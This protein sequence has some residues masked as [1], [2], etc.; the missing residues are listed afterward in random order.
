MLVP[1]SVAVRDANAVALAL[2]RTRA[3]GALLDVSAATLGGLALGRAFGRGGTGAAL[4]AAAGVLLALRWNRQRAAA[5][6]ERARPALGSALQ[7]YLEGGGGSLRPQLETWVAQRLG[8]AWLPA[9]LVRMAVAAG[10]AL[11]SQPL[12]RPHVHGTDA[13][14]PPRPGLSVTARLEPPAYAGWP[15]VEVQLPAV[16]GL[17]HSRLLLDVRTTAAGLRWAE[18]GGPEHQLLPVDGRASLSFPLERSGSL[19]L[20]AEGGGPVVLLQLEALPDGAPRVTLAAP[21]TDRTVTAAPG[22]LTLRASAQDDVQVAHLDFRWT[23]ARGSGEGMQFQNGRLPGHLTLQGQTAEAAARLDPLALGMKA[24][25][26]LVLWA[27]AS[28][29][30][31]LD[32]PGVGRSEARLVHWEEALVDLS[33]SVAGARLPPPLSQPSERELLARTER[34]VRSGARGARLR[35]QSAALGDLQRHIREAFGFFLQQESRSGLELDVD[36]AEVAMNG[37][38]RARRLLAQ[39]VSEMWS[40]EAELATG[41]PA[42]ALA[43]ERAAV[44]ALD[45]AFG[46]ERLALRPF[47]PPDRPI[48]EGRRLSGAQGGLR[49]RADG[50]ATR[51]APDDSSVAQLARRLLLSAEEGVTAETARRL[52]DAL[53]ALPVSTGIAAASL[54]A[55]LYAAEDGV[56]RDAAARAAAVALSRWLRPSPD[57]VPPVSPDEAAV[58]SRLPLRPPRP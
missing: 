50:P 5:A 6:L 38:A 40:A 58:V 42:R 9:S 1:S 48:D 2:L 28:D 49:P 24:G 13:G 12:S 57:V 23:L 39:A 51:P 26:T 33:S 35:E 21:E 31:S 29:T 34:L 45:A 27:E 54:A 15:T 44:K 52:A 17:R 10:L 11:L 32:G 4:G 43:P 25:D 18:E 37:D 56:S 16:R 19:R 46:S 47:A 20:V 30:N 36:E 14:Q 7:A 3:L 55:P 41:S 53:W 22:P 8:P